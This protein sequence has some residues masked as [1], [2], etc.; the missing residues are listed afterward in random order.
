M[1]KK[2]T[3]I[4]KVEAL[5]MLAYNNGNSIS[6][7]A[8]RDSDSCTWRIATLVSV[9]CAQGSGLHFSTPRAT[10]YQC[11]KVEEI[12]PFMEWCERT[13]LPFPNTEEI[14]RSLCRE[15]YELGLKVGSEST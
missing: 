13:Y 12:D 8:F 14:V 4:S 15:A 2:Y 6:G 7:L 3:Q 9:N 5:Q 1:K 11:A 10:Y